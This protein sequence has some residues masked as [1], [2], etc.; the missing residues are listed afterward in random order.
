M[1]VLLLYYSMS[2]LSGAEITIYCLVHKRY[3]Q[4]TTVFVSEPHKSTSEKKRLL[5]RGTY[6]EMLY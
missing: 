3:I 1:A 4:R 5:A 6:Q 2:V